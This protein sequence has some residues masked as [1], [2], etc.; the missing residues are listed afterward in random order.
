MTVNELFH[1]LRAFLHDGANGLD[2]T[3]AIQGAVNQ[4]LS[5]LHTIAPPHA[6]TARASFSFTAPKTVDIGVTTGSNLFT[7]FSPD[8][9]D[10][11]CTIRIDGDT[12]PNTIIGSGEMLHPFAGQ[13]GTVAATV[14]HDAIPIPAQYQEIVFPL[15]D[16]D[17]NWSALFPGPRVTR[18][19]NGEP[20]WA[21]VDG[22]ASGQSP[23]APLILCVNTLP[24]GLKRYQADAVLAPK[25]IT[26]ED[27]ADGT[28]PVPLPPEHIDAFLIPA[29][30]GALARTP[31]WKNESRIAS[32]I[33]SGDAAISNYSLV[34]QYPSTPANR[35][36]TPYGY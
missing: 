10:A 14:F 15:R 21:W 7:V 31:W 35:V 8:D 34:V 1:R 33:Q 22:N 18:K 36:G 23:F 19:T 17:K 29:A 24:N 4:T 26:L 12:A 3:Q 9:E 5:D 6:K 2:G 11:Y 28:V 30:I 13:T 25:R 20:E 32:A 27:M 16:I